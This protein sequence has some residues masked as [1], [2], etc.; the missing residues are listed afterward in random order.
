[1]K[2]LGCEQKTNKQKKLEQVLGNKN[3]MEPGSWE[4]AEFWEAVMQTRVGSMHVY[5]CREHERRIIQQL[6]A[7]CEQK[8]C[9][10]VLEQWSYQRKWNLRV[11]VSF[12]CLW[13]ILQLQVLS[14][15]LPEVYICVIHCPVP[16]IIISIMPFVENFKCSLRGCNSILQEVKPLVV[17]DYFLISFLCIH[18]SHGRYLFTTCISAIFCIFFTEHPWVVEVFQVPLEIKFC[19]LLINLI[20]TSYLQPIFW[21]S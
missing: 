18:C 8:Y 1:M 4:Y 2:N 5:K 12:L 9:S 19:V 16:Q 7:Q 11:S 6:L 21:N 20:K 15:S 13:V 17:T 14:V 3:N 10:I